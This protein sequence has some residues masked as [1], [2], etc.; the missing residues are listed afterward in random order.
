MK[1]LG[2]YW[3]RAR[4]GVASGVC[5]VVALLA[6]HWGVAAVAPQAWDV[7]AQRRLTLSPQTQKVLT[8]LQGTVT[9]TLFAESEVRTA[10][11]RTFDDSAAM[12][13]DLLKRY[14]QHVEKFEIERVTANDSVAGQRLKQRFPDITAPCVVITY[15]LP[16]EEPRHEVLQHED[17]AEFHGAPAGRVAGVDFFAEQTV[18]A[19]LARLAEGQPQ[20]KV[21]C[22][23]G[24]GE[25]SLV[26][27][28]PDST[29]SLSEL[30]DYLRMGGVQM[31]L[32]DLSQAT[33][34]PADADVVLLAGPQ[35]EYAAADAAKLETYFK[36]GGSGLLL[37][38]FVQNHRDGTV[39]PTGLDRLLRKWGVLP[40]NDF[41]VTTTVDKQLSTVVRALP[42]DGDH[43]LA[44]SMPRAS[45][46][47]MQA[48]SVR[49]L[50]V[51]AAPTA[52]CTPLL[53]SPDGPHCW[54]ETDVVSRNLPQWNDGSDLPGPVSLAVAVERTDRATPAPM[55]VVVG[56]AEFATNRGMTGPR[57]YAAGT[58]VLRSLHWLAGTKRAMQ[59]IPMRRSRPYQLTGTVQAQRGL[60]WK[61]ML[62]LSAL[63]STAGATVWTMRR[64]G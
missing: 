57:Q 36:H 12:L 4:R 24:H 19:A 45:L 62:F 1:F 17:L 11:E 28:G 30:A 40:G 58:F 64:H 31:E 5:V 49:L 41:V 35:A 6:A 63:V 56:D 38:D 15:Q 61:T 27:E 7:T 23:S 34:V 59:D 32:L 10:R 48:R 43:P 29:R 18:T 26:A 22:L 9:V 20:V 52:V 8:E 54:A 16:G 21:Y 14:Q 42:A 3:R 39:L 46:D 2:Q 60:V 47:F 25:A 33:H 37:L 44:R 13:S 55:L 50:P 53:L 51:T